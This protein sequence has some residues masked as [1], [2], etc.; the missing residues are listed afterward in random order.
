[1]IAVLG[2]DI[3]TVQGVLGGCDCG[4]ASAGH[5][6][7]GYASLAD[8]CRE[9]GR[10]IADKRSGDQDAVSRAVVHP[11]FFEGASEFQ[12]GEAGEQIAFQGGMAAV[13]IL[14]QQAGEAL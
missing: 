2:V 1:M 7:P 11:P 3:E 13:A 14:V 12:K 6:E 9:S 4:S 10:G 8:A 5:E